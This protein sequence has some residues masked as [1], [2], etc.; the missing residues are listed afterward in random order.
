M[1]VNKKFLLKKPPKILQ[2]KMDWRDFC[3]FFEGG[4][5][6]TIEYAVW[7]GLWFIFIMLS[8]PLFLVQFDIM[9]TVL[10]WVKL[11]KIQV[12]F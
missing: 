6:K 5:K 12:E 8:T 1:D 11:P 4:V 9:D 7:L 3:F 2:N 10:I